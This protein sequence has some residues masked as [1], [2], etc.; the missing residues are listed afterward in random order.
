MKKNCTAKQ[1]NIGLVRQGDKYLAVDIKSTDE[2]PHVMSYNARDNVTFSPD[3]FD[4][5]TYSGSVELTSDSLTNG[6]GIETIYGSY[7][8]CV[9]NKPNI[10]YLTEGNKYSS[11]IALSGSTITVD[12]TLTTTTTVPTFEGDTI[13]YNWVA[14]VN[15]PTLTVVSFYV[16]NPDVLFD[17]EF[18]FDSV[19]WYTSG[20]SVSSCIIDYA[21]NSIQITASGDNCFVYPPTTSMN[22]IAG[23]TYRITY[24]CTNA[25]KSRLTVLTSASANTGFGAHSGYLENPAS[26]DTFTVS[27]AYP[28]VV[29]RP[30][31]L[32]SKA[33][34]S[35]TYSD[36][37]VQD[38]TN[39]K[40]INDDVTG[41]SPHGFYNHAPNTALGSVAS[42]TRTGYHFDGWYDSQDA[43]G[44][45]T[46]TQYTAESKTPYTN[47]KLFSKWTVNKITLKYDG[48]NRTDGKILDNVEFEYGDSVETA[49]AA[50]R[51]YTVTYNAM[52]GTVSPT[53]DTAQ[54]TFAGWKSSAVGG[55]DYYQA[56]TAYKDGF[57][58]T[59]GSGT[60]TAMWKNG[61]LTLPTPTRTGYTFGGWYTDSGCTN[62]VTLA[63]DGKY[64]A[65][66]N[67]TLYARWDI[68]SYSFDLNGYLTDTGTI[69]GGLY[70]VDA[71]NSSNYI[72]AVK[73]DVTVGQDSEKG[74]TD[75]NV[76]VP[77]GTAFKISNFVNQTGYVFTGI[78]EANQKEYKLQNWNSST[79]TYSGYVG[80][81]EVDTKVAVGYRRAKFTIAYNLNGGSNQ[82][83]STSATFN[84]ANTIT[85]TKPTRTGYTFAGWKANDG[86]VFESGK[87]ITATQVRDLY[88]NN[89]GKD[90]GTI[91]LTAQW[92]ANSYT[93]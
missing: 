76:T 75:Y 53:S 82:P 7:L 35:I 70:D 83:A 40:G 93:V 52:N 22:L 51:K 61:G 28:Y 73:V 45:G 3:H 56:S 9:D 43:A 92:T 68:N 33:G 54:Y 50:E 57:G 23:H 71:D 31:I 72:P 60:L 67:I 4:G 24:N 63:S 41:A 86:S 65:T 55:D 58:V 36:I 91:T 14:A 8:N 11:E 5:Y 69:Y 37:Y 79:N 13:H 16:L 74:K 48:N 80:N 6:N 77:Y 46:G 49:A 20:V 32:N 34:D 78:V 15:D 2:N 66:S 29:L 62:A 88:K 84:V 27:S 89:D 42:I 87:K 85:S 18:D 1:Y 10:T 17:N 26:G 90:G 47:L 19:S 30:G 81:G 64:Y 59:G 21:A 38:I 25:E 44:N 39:Y 12:K